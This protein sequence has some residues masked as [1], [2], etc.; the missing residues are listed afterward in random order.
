MR[1]VDAH[2]HL[3]DLTVRDQAWTGDL[4]ALRRSFLLPELEP[5]AAE[6]G[7]TATVLVQTVHAVDETPEMLA[8]ADTSELVAGVVG[9]TDVTV[10]T[11]GE[12]LSDLLS[13]PGGRYLVGIRHQVQE[14][15]DG[16]WLTQPET[17]RGLRQL[18]SAG[19]AFDLIV[20]RDQLPDCVAVARAVPELSFVLDH[21]GKPR[22]AT[23]EMEPWA[24]H[25]RTLAECPNVS[26]KLSG[27]LTEADVANWKV[28]DLRPYAEVVLEAFGPDRVM[29]GSDWPVSTLAAEYAQV[30]DTA[31]ELTA[32]LA[33]GERDAVLGG[34]ATKIYGLA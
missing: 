24:T 16:A 32:D 29:F 30:V 22:I 20:R 21:L 14:L 7:V 17:L 10:P 3:W 12:R 15:P 13:G 5:L 2:H 11:F 1:I 27:M 26:C 19:L 25:V 18:A 8:L 23:H 6:A 31:K 34:T 4:P 33:D 9:W 28:A